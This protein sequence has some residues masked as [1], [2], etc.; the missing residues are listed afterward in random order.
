MLVLTLHLYFPSIPCT[1]RKEVSLMCRVV[2]RVAP[3][4]DTLYQLVSVDFFS[5]AHWPSAVLKCH[6]L[7]ATLAHGVEDRHDPVHQLTVQIS[8]NWQSSSGALCSSF[9]RSLRPS[10]PQH[11]RFLQWLTFSQLCK[12]KNPRRFFQSGYILLRPREQQAQSVP[13]SSLHNG[14]SFS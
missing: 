10:P 7:S 9:L 1:G 5:D 3:R 8:F 12:V 14:F 4:R 6:R 13:H 11:L 2:V